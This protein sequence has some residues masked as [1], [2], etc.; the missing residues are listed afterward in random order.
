MQTS[1]NFFA[2]QHLEE[3]H[4]TIGGQLRQ[5]LDFVKHKLSAMAANR[6]T[7][8]REFAQLR[9]ANM[10][11]GSIKYARST[12]SI[13][14]D[15]IAWALQYVH[16]LFQQHHEMLGASLL[17]RAALILKINLSQ[18]HVMPEDMAHRIAN[19]LRL[20]EKPHVA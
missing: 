17:E 12:M 20:L 15:E 13:R 9:E 16:G 6:S 1:P 2:M 5:T 8:A 19:E 14:E 7:T 4:E 11:I 18:T 3:V 10:L